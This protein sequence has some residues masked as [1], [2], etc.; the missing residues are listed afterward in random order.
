MK[1]TKKRLRSTVVC[2]LEDDF[3][4]IELEDPTTRKR[5]WSLPGGQIEENES[6]GDAA[7]RETLEETGYSVALLPE[8]RAVS[9]YIFRWNAQIYECT[10]H[11]FAASLANPENLIVDDADYLLG[12]RW[13]PIA[14]ICELFSYHP[15]VRDY[16][17]KFAED[18]LT[19]R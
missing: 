14:R 13:L 7:V 5:M 6:P 17:K 8:P 11:W 16:T 2:I 18:L 15:H 12:H 9:N 19:L 4:A 3:L 10:N 1:E